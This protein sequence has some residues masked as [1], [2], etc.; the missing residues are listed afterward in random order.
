MTYWEKKT[1]GRAPAA[2]LRQR[3]PA[4]TTAEES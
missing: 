3:V 4:A 1:P 2:C